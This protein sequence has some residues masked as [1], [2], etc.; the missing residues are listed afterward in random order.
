MRVGECVGCV[1]RLCLDS[2]FFV[3]RR[4]VTID[5][6]WIHCYTPWDQEVIKTMETQ[7]FSVTKEDTLREISCQSYGVSFWGCWGSITNWL[8]SQ[9]P[10]IKKVNITLR[11]S[12]NKFM[13]KYL[14]WV[15][16]GSFSISNERP[17]TNVI[18]M[19]KWKELICLLLQHSLYS[20]DFVPSVFHI[21]PRLKIFLGEKDFSRK[22]K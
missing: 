19:E 14:V 4:F 6:I 15:R 3:R 2:R 5:D 1:L 10:V 7:W 11:P 20:P 16:R 8:S 22:E 12:W 9:E 17:H 21:F 18:A 13:K